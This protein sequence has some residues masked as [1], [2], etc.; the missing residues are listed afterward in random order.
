[1]GALI[2]DARMGRDLT[3]KQLATA[4][5]VSAATVS[6]VER[7]SKGVT[8]ATAEKILAAMGLQ[9]HV[10]T[11][12]LWADVDAAI[13]EM[14][15]IPV[16][17]RIGRWEIGFTSFVSWFAGRSSMAD[18]LMAAAL[19]GAPVP[20]RAFEMVIADDDDSIDDMISLLG[21]MRARQWVDRWQS[22]QGSCLDPRDTECPPARYR[23]RH[24][25]FRVRLAG[26][27]SPKVWVE[28]E[29]LPAPDLAPVSLFQRVPLLTRARL[30][31]VPLTEIETDEAYARRVLDRV[32]EL[33]G[34]L[35]HQRTAPDSW[36]RVTG[37]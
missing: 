27:L 18:G 3:L 7:A 25:E 10:E 22:R 5:G 13:E 17:D 34:G 37:A 14:R 8:L 12:P 6:A 20:V 31:V 4:S 28:L 33:S 23:C 26:E 29:D 11:Q 35:P 21:E 36:G 1:M 9:L 16:P 30:P 32:R 2:R 19:Q 24:G 15:D